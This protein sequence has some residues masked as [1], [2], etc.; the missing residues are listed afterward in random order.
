MILINGIY[1]T[2]D[3]DT[4]GLEP[5]RQLTSEERAIVIEMSVY[6]NIYH[7]KTIYD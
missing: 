7:Y 1:V 5:E 3:D 4:I 2:L 6:D